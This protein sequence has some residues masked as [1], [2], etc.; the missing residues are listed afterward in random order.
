MT[1]LVS[2]AKKQVY[3]NAGA[4]EEM[5]ERG[6]EEAIW[7]LLLGSL[8][9]EQALLWWPRCKEPLLPTAGMTRN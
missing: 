2:Q 8:S 5:Q 1:G 6:G 3:K 4:M 7:T 9:V